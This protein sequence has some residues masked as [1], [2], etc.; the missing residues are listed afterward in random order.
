MS[1]PALG[2][3]DAGGW[4]YDNTVGDG[5]YGNIIVNCT[6]TDT[7]GTIWTAYLGA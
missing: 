5:W 7:K 1:T 6:H 2:I 3:T 4:G